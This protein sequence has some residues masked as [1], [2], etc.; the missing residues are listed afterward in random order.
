MDNIIFSFLLFFALVG[1]FIICNFLEFS[2]D[3]ISK[4]IIL[5]GGILTIIVMFLG[6][7]LYIVENKLF[8]DEELNLT[9]YT[10]LI[11]FHLLTWLYQTKR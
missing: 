10:C 5:I 3:K 2:K 7:E 11:I 8:R 4:I 1:S 6:L 9:I